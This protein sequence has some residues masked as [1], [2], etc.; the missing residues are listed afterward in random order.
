MYLLN[1][2]FCQHCRGSCYLSENS[3][4]PL[5]PNKIST[6]SQ[7][8]PIYLSSCL[9]AFALG[10]YSSYF[11]FPSS[12]PSLWILCQQSTFCHTWDENRHRKNIQL[13]LSSSVPHTPQWTS[14]AQPDV[15]NR[16]PVSSLLCNAK[17]NMEIRLGQAASLQ[18]SFLHSTFWYISEA[19]WRCFYEFTTREDIAIPLISQY[20][21]FYSILPLVYGSSRNI[22]STAGFNFYMESVE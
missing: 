6:C 14:S 15:A 8:H 11:L 3:L 19:D 1:N 22:I 2:L 12:S 4:V 16:S 13:W 5:L 21:S 9:L 10:I 7:C 20:V 18:V 17:Y